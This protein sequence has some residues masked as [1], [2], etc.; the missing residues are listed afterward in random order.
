MSNE[1]NSNDHDLSSSV[2]E[3][4]SKLTEKEI[5]EKKQQLQSQTIFYPVPDQ[6]DLTTF[7]VDI[8]SIDLSLTRLTTLS[9]FSRFTNL[10]SLC[11]RSNLLKT[12]Q[13]EQFKVQNGLGQI[14]ELD[15]YDNQIEVIENLNQFTTLEHLDLSFNRLRKVENLEQL[16]NLKKLFFV[17]NE[18]GK[19][20][21]LESLVNLELLELGDNKLRAIENLESLQKLTELLVFGYS[22]FF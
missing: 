12:F 21:N 9:N 18:I 8:D 14:K 16:I 3:T 7:S 6:V 10:L 20:E 2:P 13:S 15:F 11:F 1:A 4:N 17:H 5:V 19:I 22:V